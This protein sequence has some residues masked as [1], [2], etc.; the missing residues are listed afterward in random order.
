MHAAGHPPAAV[1][2]VLVCLIGSCCGTPPEQQRGEERGQKRKAE[3]K[4]EE[5]EKRSRNRFFLGVATTA[6][7]EQFFRQE[8]GHQG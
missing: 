1:D 8:Q 2:E 6:I 7:I 4:R 5:P 3:K